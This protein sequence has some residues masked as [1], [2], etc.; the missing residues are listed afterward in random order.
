MTI[1][2]FANNDHDKICEE[3]NV[4]CKNAIQCNAMQCDAM[5][6]NVMNQITTWSEAHK[7]TKRNVE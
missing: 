4:Q 2:K 7:E 6:Y 3:Y 1:T 5:Q